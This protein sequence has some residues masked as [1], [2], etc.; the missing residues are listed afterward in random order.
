M[1]SNNTSG[2]KGVYLIKKRG[3]WLAQIVH[4]GK[5]IFLGYYESAE[6]AAIARETAAEVFHGEFARCE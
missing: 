3:R 6:E 5:Q 2:Y 4:N 1:Q